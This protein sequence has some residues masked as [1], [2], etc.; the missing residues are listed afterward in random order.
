M[1]DQ[2]T[3]CAMRN[4]WF[5]SGRDRVTV[6]NRAGSS[7]LVEW[8]NAD[9]IRQATL[10]DS[11][12]VTRVGSRLMDR[13]LAQRY[14]FSVGLVHD[15]YNSAQRANVVAEWLCTSH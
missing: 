4:G 11:D 15:P 7:V 2:I 5:V 9:T 14:G 8:T 13:S 10:R 3:Q 6:F 1:R 12:G